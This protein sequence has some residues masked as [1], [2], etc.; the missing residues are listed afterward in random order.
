MQGYAYAAKQWLSELLAERAEP[1][2]GEL[3]AWAARL[4]AEAADLKARFNRD[5]WRPE[6]R[7]FGMGLDGQKR[8]VPAMT[9]NPGHGLLCGIVDEEKA[10]ALVARLLAPDMDGGW[11]I[12][13]LSADE[14]Q[15]NPMSY[16][17]GT[18]WP[19]DN[20]LIVA[21]MRRY[22]YAREANRVIGEL[23]DAAQTYRYLR[24]PELYCGFPRDPA[25]DPTP[26]EYPV[27][28]SPQAWAAGTAYLCLQSLLGLRPGPGPDEVT[29]DPVLPPWLNRLHLRRLRA[30][31][32]TLDLVVT[33]A[34]GDRATVEVLA[35]SGGMRVSTAASS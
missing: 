3:A 27:S 5:F 19:H 35:A 26:A 29:L 33:R 7:T 11:G 1:G 18:V 34:D 13:T 15:Y 24:L 16:H 10:G 14:P 4:A 32:G 22:G 6:A 30:G 20:S 23:F 2:E 17:N 31:H 8:L 28:C 25:L 21:G 12:R 9:T